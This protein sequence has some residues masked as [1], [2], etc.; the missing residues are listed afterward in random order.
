MKATRLTVLGMSGALLLSTAMQA[1]AAD[2][3][4]TSGQLLERSRL[5]AA[6]Y[7]R[8][9][10]T[11]D[12]ATQR[13]RVQGMQDGSYNGTPLQTRQQTRTQEQSRNREHTYQGGSSG[14]RYG[15]GYESRGGN[16][17]YGAGSDGS[18]S[19]SGG[20]GRSGGKGGGRR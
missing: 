17:G 18:G 1:D 8:G 11:G 7:G 16:G 13:N 4:V 14:S 15:Q 5:H 9:L 19:G 3:T 2:S 6:D 10:P 12:A 20:S